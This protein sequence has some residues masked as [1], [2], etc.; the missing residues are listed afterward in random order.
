LPETI[1]LSAMV[2]VADDV[3][4]SELGSEHVLLNLRDGTYYGLE[5]VGS[6]I[7]KMVQNP[8]SVAEICEAIVETH[9]VDPE[10]CRRDVVKL[11]GEL[12][13]RRLVELCGPAG[14]R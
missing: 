13:E 3:L 7:W 11:L 1:P 9:E 4:S 8:V 14:R 10:R 2:V 12:M 5:D 6:H